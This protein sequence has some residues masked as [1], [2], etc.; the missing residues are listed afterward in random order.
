MQS[1][2]FRF[3]SVDG[4]QVFVRTW[5]PDLVRPRAA[6]LIAHGAAEHGMRYERIASVLT[7]QCYAVYAPDHRGHG[8]TAASLD[9]A[10][11][12]GPDGFN[13]MIRDLKQLAE[14]ARQN[15]SAMPLFL[16]GHSMGA[17]LS[18]R[19]I[20]MHGNLLSGVIL[21]GSPGIRPNLE[22]A[23]V[24]TTQLAQGEKAEQVSE[25]FKQSFASFNEGLGVVKNGYEWLSRDEAEV[26]KYVDDPWCGFPFTNRLVAEM[27]QCALE[28]TRSENIARIPKSLSIFLFAGS[29]DRVGGNGE[30]V[31]KL[32]ELYR[33][34]GIVDVQVTMYPNGRH[35][36]LNETNR[37]QV[38]GDL[39]AW[40]QERA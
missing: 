31:N 29:H 5:L 13:G 27:A 20:Q 18:Q 17:A 7:T 2:T 22:Q 11:N 30:C 9:N 21:S 12:A 38:H 1:S 35:E 19:F 39:V 34:A 8:Q 25:L 4:P 10:G 3:V 24:Y 15:H 33:A 36:M 40:L 23:A 26:Q 14:L 6:I 37:E 32:A 28:A 16:F